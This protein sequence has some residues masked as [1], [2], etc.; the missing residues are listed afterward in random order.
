V[1]AIALGAAAAVQAEP[2]PFDLAGPDL[3]V[4]VTRGSRT[5]P[6]AEVPNLA[7]GDR[8]W[9]HADLPVTQTARYLLVAAFLR[10]STNPPPANWFFSCE[11]WKGKCAQDGLT[12]AVPQDAQQML[13]F[14]APST[15]GDFKTLVSAV[16]GRPGAFV[17]SSQ[18]LNQASLDRERLEQY[19]AAIRSLND[20]DPAKVAGA[21]PLL[22]RSASTGP[23]CCR[24]RA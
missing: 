14:L 9:L 13:L 11:T 21:A 2:A 10:G 20:T 17:R 15:G 12:V 8:V 3:Q 1:L 6:I 23:P 5:L 16:Q 4:K 22:T 19:L 18:D 24:R 7:V